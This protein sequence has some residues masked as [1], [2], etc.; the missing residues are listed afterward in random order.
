MP[1]IILILAVMG[2]IILRLA[3]RQHALVGLPPGRVVFLDTSQFVR[4]QNA[5]YDPVTGLSGKPDYL[6]RDHGAITPVELKSGRAPLQPYPG[7][8]LQ[9]AAYCHL[10][11]EIYGQRPTYGIIKYAD[12]SF[13]IDFDSRVENQ[14]L[15]ILAEMRRCEQHMPDRSHDSVRRCRACGHKEICDQGLD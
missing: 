1:I 15:D 8:I 13:A 12:K 2:L 5:L 4:L 14:L 7:H 11:G 9:L 3:K 10:A 6:I